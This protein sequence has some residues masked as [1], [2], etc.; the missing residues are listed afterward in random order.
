MRFLERMDAIELEVCSAFNRCN[1]QRLLSRTFGT[2]S[3][4]G[5]G[6]FWY[7]LMVLLPFI[8]GWP[9]GVAAIHMAIVGLISL[10]LYKALKA[11]TTR[12]RPCNRSDTLTRSVAPLDEF[13]FPSGHTMHAVGFTVVL[14]HYFPVW[15]WLVVPFALMV[16][17]S[18]LVLGLHYP[19]DVV[20]G[21]GIGFSVAYLS[22]IALGAW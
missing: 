15:A 1:R 2:V 16:A 11:S 14:L 22:L 12:C 9:G 17:A 7:V 8:Y 13:S 4:L 20:V 21:A 10:P 18:R 6:V 5:D 19:S 3:R